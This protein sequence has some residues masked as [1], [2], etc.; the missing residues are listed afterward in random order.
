MQSK[1]NHH[2]NGVTL[3][4][5]LIAVAL[6][7]VFVAVVVPGFL[8]ARVRTNVTKVEN[9]QRNLAT[10]V[11]SYYIDH[12]T[13][14]PNNMGETSSVPGTGAG[15]IQ[16]L[17]SLSTPIAYIPS[18]IIEDPFGDECGLWS[19]GIPIIFYFNT[20]EIDPDAFEAINGANISEDKK[21]TAF[22][23]S[24]WLMSAGPDRSRLIDEIAVAN[25][26][27]C[28]N[29]QASDL[30]DWFGEMR[31]LTFPGGRVGPDHLLYDPS[32]G[33]IS[34]GDIFRTLGIP[35]PDIWCGSGGL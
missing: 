5:V 35:R 8:R 34:G 3:I 11:E 13:Y 32:N 23:H 22:G 16:A 18:S 19:D 4:E 17:I 1:T 2:P 28:A 21:R 29:I 6:G 12:S 20:L 15:T 25:H 26:G 27:D 7:A 14:P 24:F 30:G 9:A 10:A 33:T 31:P